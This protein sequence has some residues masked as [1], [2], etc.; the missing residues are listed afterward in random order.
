MN[1]DIKELLDE[2]EFDPKKLFN[3]EEYSTLIINREGFNKKQNTAADLIEGLLDKEI[4]REQSEEIFTKLKDSNAH[5]LLVNSIKSADRTEEKAILTAACWESGLD[6]TN[7][8]LFFVELACSDDFK[9]S[10]EAL[11]VVENCEGTI[12]ENTLTKALEK[13]QSANTKNAVLI[14][15]LISNI[16]QRNISG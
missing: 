4:T 15:D 3:E 11:T 2:E 6:F 16:K 12:D 1:I 7:D 13:A 10:L 9:L 8:F 14:D 5:Q